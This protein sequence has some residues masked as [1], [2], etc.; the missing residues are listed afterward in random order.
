MDAEKDVS[1]DGK[2]LGLAL[3][4]DGKIEEI[5]FVRQFLSLK[6]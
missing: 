3:M 4:C 1:L 2:E 6:G 5:R